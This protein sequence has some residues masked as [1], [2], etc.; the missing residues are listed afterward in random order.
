[1]T[2]E[3]FEAIRDC[4]VLVGYR[5]YVQLVL[6]ML[7]G[8]LGGEK[9]IIPSGMTQEV[10]RARLAI[11]RALAGQKVCL[12]SGGDPGIYGMAGVVLEVL[13]EE[14]I[15]RLPI[16]IIPGITSASACA[17]LLGAPLMNDFVVISLSDRLTDLRLIEKRIESACQGDFV[18]VL[19]NP[20]SRTRSEP[21]KKAWEILMRYRSPETVVGVVRN[22]KRKGERVRITHLRSLSTFRGIDMGTTIVV[23]NSATYIK[24]KYMITPRGYRIGEGEA[25]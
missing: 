13:R 10:E 12:V 8:D 22:A 15:L 5:G 2:P 19:Y 7:K 23:G 9:E 16:E 4:E 25:R 18:L 11:E 14:E 3:A 21:F 24:G 20:K 6:N 17:S 1:M